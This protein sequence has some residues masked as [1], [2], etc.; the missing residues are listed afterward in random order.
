MATGI[1]F[2]LIGFFVFL[3]TSF[4]S[5]NKIEPIHNLYYMFAWWSYIIFVDGIIQIIKKDSLIISRTKE[6]FIM[7]PI[8]AAMWFIFEII[9]IRIENWKY[10][11]IPFDTKMRYT[12]YIISYATVLPAI[13]ETAELIQTLNIFKKLRLRAINLY[14]KNLKYFTYSGIIM[15]VL[16]IALPKYFFPFTWIFLTLIV[17]PINYKLGLVS[18]I[19]EIRAARWEKFF[20]LILSGFLCGILWEMWNFNAGAKWIYTVPFVGNFKIFEMPLAGYLGFPVF[21]IECYGI[22]NL[23]SYLRRGITWEEDRQEPIENLKNISEYWLYLLLL[24][25]IPFYLISCKLIDKYNVNLFT[26][27]Y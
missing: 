22:Y 26:L 18:L 21:A 3:I 9:N 11:N 14:E 12:G 1:L 23:F 8:S 20:S 2:T 16:I 10:V 6:F 19:R 13:F 25:L 15:F 24:S 27:L 4:L 17:E 5:I 7:L